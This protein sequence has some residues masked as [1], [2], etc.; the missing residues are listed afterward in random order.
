MKRLAGLERIENV[1]TQIGDVGGVARYQDHAVGLGGC[2][3]QAVDN[4]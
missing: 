4:Q 3:Q 1:N 2:R